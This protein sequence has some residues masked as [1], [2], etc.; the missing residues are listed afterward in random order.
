MQKKN[1]QIITNT[2]LS[3]QRTQRENVDLL[4][5]IKIMKAAP[6]YF[7]LQGSNHQGATTST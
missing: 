4:K 7:H 6:T 1:I 2:L 5:H 3:N